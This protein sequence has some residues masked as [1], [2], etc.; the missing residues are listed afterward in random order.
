MAKDNVQNLKCPFAL[1]RKMM[2]K[3]KD[4]KS[5]GK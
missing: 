1:S 5:T 2:D 4:R 3:T